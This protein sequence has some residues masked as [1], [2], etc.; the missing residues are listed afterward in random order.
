MR[1][2]LL[3]TPVPEGQE[4]Q[5]AWHGR[6]PSFASAP[7]QGWSS[8]A[9]ATE[10]IGIAG[11]DGGFPAALLAMAG[12]DLRQPLQIITWAHNVL[13]RTLGNDEQREELAR[14]EDAT[15]QLTAMLGQLV[16]AVQL[17]ELRLGRPEIVSLGPSLEDLAAEFAEAARLKSVILRVPPTRASVFSHSV[18]LRGILRNLIR[19]AI[20]YTPRG[21]LVAVVCRRYG[22]E[23]RIEVRDS[24]PGIRAETLAR[25]FEAFER[26]DQ[27]R[28]NGLG[29]GLFIVKRAADLLGHRVEVRS[30]VGC[31]S[32]FTVLAACAPTAAQRPL[33]GGFTVARTTVPA[34]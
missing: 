12:H 29:L 8:P 34:D 5:M 26:A 18:L 13:A 11:G 1:F 27:T 25:L 21:G 7:L 14:A 3:P 15:T 17:H 9:A 23:L 20:D 10:P 16:E 6:L 19:N 32:R 31:G 30:A 33:H 4:E 24:G 28:A 22:A 2:T